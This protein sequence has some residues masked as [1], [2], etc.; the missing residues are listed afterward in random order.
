MTDCSKDAII[1]SIILQFSVNSPCVNQMCEVIPAFWDMVS[2]EACGN[3]Y[4]TA[5]LTKR[6]AVLFLLGCEAYSV[7]EA[8]SHYILTANAKADTRS[9]S[10]SQAQA[11]G[12]SQKVAEG[13]GESRY[14][15]KADASSVYNSKRLGRAKDSTDGDSFY[16]DDG[17]GFGYNRSESFSFI[18]NNILHTLFRHRESEGK[19]RDRSRNC[20][21]EY[22]QNNTNGEGYNFGILGASFSGTAS[23]W[24][25][26]QSTQTKNTDV[27]NALEF[28][29][30]DEDDQ[31][32]NRTRGTHNW[33]DTFLADIDW[34]EQEH[35]LRF[36]NERF[37]SRKV[38]Q[39][40]SDGNGD[41]ISEEKAE[42]F[43]ASQGTSQTVA[44]S[45]AL[46]TASRVS[47]LTAFA[48]SNSQRFAN[49]ES[50]Y[51]QLTEQ[52]IRLRRRLRA[53]ATP[54]TGI[55]PCACKSNCCCSPQQR[56]L[57]FDLLSN[58]RTSSCSSGPGLLRYS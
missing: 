25:K 11:T 12:S 41:G 51:D 50:L 30:G 35:I 26:F 10:R 46:R 42:G 52:I 4:L 45:E 17:K 1:C 21:Y 31:G 38:A 16:R 8:Q 19:G 53:T 54:Y 14:D 24:R 56:R 58:C 36:H 37:D 13:H 23:E 32:T 15:E 18:R 9:D 29:E 5:L 2:A 7:D 48:I 43:Q 49:L 20:N 22:S 40:H 47:N 39:A 6:E 3:S 44:D 57:G 28:V 33:E 34:Y 27:H 55:I